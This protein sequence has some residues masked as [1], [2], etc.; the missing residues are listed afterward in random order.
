MRILILVHAFPPEMQAGAELATFHLAR[1]LRARHEVVV[2]YVSNVARDHDHI[3]T[4]T[5]ADVPVIRLHSR[6]RPERAMA[7][8]LVH[9]ALE[10]LLLEA[11][12]AFRPEVVHVQHAI[13]SS[14]NV[15]FRLKAAGLPVVLTLH[16]FWFLCPRINLFRPDGSLCAGPQGGKACV[17]AGCYP[18]NA[19]F[20]PY[21]DREPAPA[22]VAPAPAAPSSPPPASR[23]SRL[24]GAIPRPLK[25][26][27]PP[28]LKHRLASRFGAPTPVPSPLVPSPAPAAPPPAPDP[29]DAM[30]MEDRA[31]FMFDALGAPDHIISPS[32]H[33][34]QRFV[35]HG[36]A[37]EQISVIRNVVDVAGFG[38]VGLPPP[39]PPVVFG[40]I[41]TLWPHKGVQVLIEA[42][43]RLAPEAA[44]LLIVGKGE[45]RY[46]ENLRRHARNPAIEFLGEVPAENVPEIYERLHAL[47]LPSICYDNWPVTMQEAVA[48]R[49]PIIASDIG[50]MAEA[51]KHERNALLFAAGDAEALHKQ[52]VRVVEDPQALARFADN[53]PPPDDP[54]QSTAA[55]EAVYRRLVE[56]AQRR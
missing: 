14:A 30:F 50:G 20:D 27:A 13:R 16:D 6:P 9:P 17:P 39:A 44:R 29:R 34:R 11:V 5:Y 49:R 48:A 52:L 51:L 40:Y 41:G 15:L 18:G 3:T 47:V 28:G 37:P 33:L 22:V 56:E 46:E 55:H 21:A 54:E 7:M 23:F 2:A 10:H 45:A 26:L 53:L 31:R 12:R 24:V 38:R 36:A 8:G 32:A 19:W 1:R 4:G 43:N 25:A 42:A 35:E